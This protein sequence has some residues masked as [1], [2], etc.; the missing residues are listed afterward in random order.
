MGTH[1][2]LCGRI[3]VA[4]GDRAIDERELPGRQ[5]RLALALLCL[6]RRRP[7]S[8][9]RLVTALWD[10]NP[11]PDPAG[12][13]ASVVSKLRA[14]LWRAGDVGPDVIATG[15][16]T[17]HLR[18]P[19]DSAIDLED[20]RHAIDHAEGARRRDDVGAT[21]AD[22]TVATSIVRRGFLPGES[23][24]WVLAV[25]RGSTASCSGATTLSM[26]CG[27]PAATP[28]WPRPWP[29]KPSSSHRCTSRHGAR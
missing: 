11:P 9:D 29:S 12:S 26:W 20:A 21:W 13:L 22:A 17:Y 7:V 25:Q 4:G 27:P 24:D 10:E 3:A 1:V 15:A 19:V 16:G 6:D 8:V 5:G 2:Y 14:V 28:C 18:L 23:A